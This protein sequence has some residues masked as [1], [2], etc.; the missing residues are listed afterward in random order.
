MVLCTAM[1]HEHI[2]VG[3][4]TVVHV[5]LTQLM[6]IFTFNT[7]RPVFRPRMDLP[8]GLHS[9]SNNLVVLFI[10]TTCFFFL[11]M[12]E[13]A[14]SFLFLWLANF[15]FAVESPWTTLVKASLVHAY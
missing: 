1:K 2:Q 7:V 3:S 6:I 10:P 13:N 4:C 9:F 12:Q 11:A 14:V 8:R 15:D 5:K